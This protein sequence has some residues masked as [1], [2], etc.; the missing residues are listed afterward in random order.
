MPPASATM[1]TPSVALP[2]IEHGTIKSSDVP[3][4]SLLPQA[5]PSVAGSTKGLAYTAQY[6]AII[7]QNTITVSTASGTGPPPPP[8]VISSGPGI[9]EIDLRGVEAWSVRYQLV[10]RGVELMIQHP[11]FQNIPGLRLVLKNHSPP[12]RI[13][14]EGQVLLVS[15][16]RPV[17]IMLKIGK[18]KLKI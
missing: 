10:L 8:P 5:T 18:Y 16:L 1:P 13:T 6:G 14:N 7:P 12:K 9:S 15:H 2:L 17:L 4:S 3:M 11:L